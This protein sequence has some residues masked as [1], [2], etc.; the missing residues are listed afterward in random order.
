MAQID[1]ELARA[2]LVDQRVDLQ[3]LRLGEV[4]DVVDQLVELVDAGDGIA[5]PAADGAARAADRRGQRI[6]GVRVFV[7]E[8]R[9]A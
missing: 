9:A 6:V 8:L 3:P 7:D 4:V 5:L 2:F 1:L